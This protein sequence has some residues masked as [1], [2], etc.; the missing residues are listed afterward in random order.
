MD[1]A[2]AP[3]EEEEESGVHGNLSEATEEPLVSADSTLEAVSLRSKPKFEMST[4]SLRW[5]EKRWYMDG[6]LERGLWKDKLES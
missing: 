4:E 5:A 3:A 1:P 6:S 2:P